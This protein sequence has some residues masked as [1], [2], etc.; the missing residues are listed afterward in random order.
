MG[1]I[2]ASGDLFFITKLLLLVVALMPILYRHQ[3]R[4]TGL[5]MILTSV[6]KG[7][8]NKNR[9]QSSNEIKKKWGGDAY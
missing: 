4:L 3:G 6:P 7:I 1:S 5:S 9:G 8:I 2:F